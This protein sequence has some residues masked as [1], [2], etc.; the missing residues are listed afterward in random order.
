MPRDNK[1]IHLAWRVGYPVLASLT[2]DILG[3]IKMAA[4]SLYS[5][6]SHLLNSH[7]PFCH[8]KTN[9][10]PGKSVQFI[11][12]PRRG[13]SSKM[14]KTKMNS[15][16]H[17]GFFTIW[18]H[19]TPGGLGFISDSMG[20]KKPIRRRKG[21]ST[22]RSSENAKGSLR[23]HQCVLWPQGSISP[24][25]GQQAEG[26]VTKFSDGPAKFTGS[27]ET[28]NKKY[29]A[30]TWVHAMVCISSIRTFHGCSYLHLQFH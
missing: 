30:C 28:L 16:K 19:L 11:S 24:P 25:F 23:N 22:L 17:L 13:E 2:V 18:P 14:S 1:W 29:M 6:F 15:N 26:E 12:S 9:R 8:A 10:G 5:L 4:P 3:G 27:Q 20:T 21:K 7:Y